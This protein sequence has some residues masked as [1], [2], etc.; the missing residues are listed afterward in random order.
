MTATDLA[1]TPDPTHWVLA[2]SC[3][4]RP[5]I[6]HAVSGVLAEHGGNITESQQYGDPETD[7]F[8][9]RVQ[10]RTL[11]EPGV[12]RA[13]VAE[14]A[15]RFDMTWTLDVV[16]RPIRTLVLVSK[17]AHC[18]NDLLFRQ[19][20]EGLEIDVVGV[21]GNHTDLATL[22]AFYDK[23]FH[24]I[25]VTKET[26]PDAEAALLALV[27]ELDVELVVLARDQAGAQKVH[28]RT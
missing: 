26:K 11:A 5:G 6:V 27:D 19:R 1:P 15:D 3:P 16:G 8:F 10:V 14:L 9:M 20:S 17:A 21:V 12:L 13:A 7:R 25:P 18:L 4:D 28:R 2:L 23:P 22:A 24:H